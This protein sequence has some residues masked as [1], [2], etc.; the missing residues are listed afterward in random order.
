M[1]Q[2]FI[3]ITV[4]VYSNSSIAQ[5]T[6]EYVDITSLTSIYTNAEYNGKFV[7]HGTSFFLQVKN[8]V[9]LIT[10]NHIVGGK[11]HTDE[12]NRLHPKIKGKRQPKDT[13]PNTLTLKLFQENLLS[14]KD[15]IIQ[16]KDVH[17][18]DN[19][20]K[21]YQNPSDT[22]TLL[23]VVAIPLTGLNNFNGKIVGFD[24]LMINNDVL[25]Y[26]GLDVFIVGY[27]ETTSY[28]GYPIWKRGT[29][30]SE[31]SFSKIGDPTYFIDATTRGGMSGSPVL[32]RGSAFSY[33]G[34]K[35][36]FTQH[37]QVVTYI[38]G[39]YSAQ[40]YNTEL[41]VVTNILTVYNQLLKLSH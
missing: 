6:K 33:K 40:Q 5:N 3:S 27:P 36:T 34:D 41:G 31:A 21:I 7:W 10:N 37:L 14:F 20:I 4:L 39:I 28:Y 13:I 17:G 22:S 15:E 30:A 26:P 38:I 8:D 2:L 11:Y 35:G 9:Y 23:D 19:Y 25:L 29:I 32:L 12:F 1:K 24:S 18:N 16:L